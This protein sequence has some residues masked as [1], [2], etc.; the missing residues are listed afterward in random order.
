MNDSEPGVDRALNWASN[1]ASVALSKAM[2]WP[3]TTTGAILGIIA[4]A[5]LISFLPK[6]RSGKQAPPSERVW[7]VMMKEVYERDQQVRTRL[8]EDTG[9]DVD[10]RGVFETMRDQTEPPPAAE[11][12][13]SSES[14]P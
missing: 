4:L 7:Q 5:V 13:Q 1:A 12:P 10:F 6:T 8:G 11:E 3:K 2:L 14:H 9:S